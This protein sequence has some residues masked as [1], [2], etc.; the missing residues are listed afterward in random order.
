MCCTLEKGEFR[1]PAEGCAKLT[2]VKVKVKGKFN[3]ITGHEGPE[4]E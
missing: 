3:L 4:E 2:L 1:Q